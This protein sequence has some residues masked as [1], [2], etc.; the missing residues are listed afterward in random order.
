MLVGDLCVG[1][2]GSSRRGIVIRW[3]GVLMGR[4]ERSLLLELVEHGVAEGR[5]HL[6]LFHRLFSEKI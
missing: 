5:N 4:V 3:R 2:C 1:G 6:K